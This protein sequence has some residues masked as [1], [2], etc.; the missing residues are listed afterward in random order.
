MDIIFLLDLAGIKVED[1]L[2]FVDAGH[3]VLLAASPSISDNIREIA[4]QCN[5]EFDEEE[6]YVIDHSN[7]DVSDRDGDHTLIVAGKHHFY[8]DLA[9]NIIYQI[10]ICNESLDLDQLDTASVVL[11]G[12]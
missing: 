6:T 11:G 12:N 5:I 10:L 8:D 4:S 9:L 1:V 2:S 3:N 7:Y